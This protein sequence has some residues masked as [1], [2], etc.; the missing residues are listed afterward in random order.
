MI[1]GSFVYLTSA[2]APTLVPVSLAAQVIFAWITIA[3][4]LYSATR[5]DLMLGHFTIGDLDAR[6]GVAPAQ[7]F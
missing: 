6:L 4:Q 1:L 3:G 5:I 2:G 7:G